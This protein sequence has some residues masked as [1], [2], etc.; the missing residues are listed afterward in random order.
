MEKGK[1]LQMK[2]RDGGGIFKVCNAGGLPIA[3]F[4][5]R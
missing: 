2:I 3:E 5:L 1:L 4:T